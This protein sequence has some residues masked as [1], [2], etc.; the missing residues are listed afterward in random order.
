MPIGI[1]HHASR[2][3]TA[4]GRLLVRAALCVFLPGPIVTWCAEPTQLLHSIIHLSST[5]LHKFRPCVFS[6]GISPFDNDWDQNWA[7]T[8]G[9]KSPQTTFLLG[10]NK[11]L[12]F[13]SWWW[14]HLWL[15][16]YWYTVGTVW[17]ACRRRK[18]R[19]FK[20]LF[21]DNQSIFWNGVF[22]LSSIYPTY[23]DKIFIRF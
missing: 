22:V 16:N 2:T 23:T 19:F 13:S 8:R 9:E 15:S 7:N 4:W 3:S 11:Q 21:L 10:L 6:Q 20:G 5:G 18:W 1:Q 12:I 14:N 17:L